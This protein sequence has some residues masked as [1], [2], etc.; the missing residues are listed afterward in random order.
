MPEARA[1][2]SYIA[3]SIATMVAASASSFGQDGSEES[4]WR[5]M[6][7]DGRRTQLS[8][9]IP[10]NE[11]GELHY[12]LTCS[13][14]PASFKVTLEL[15]TSL[16]ALPAHDEVP[17]ELAVGGNAPRPAVWKHHTT[18][19]STAL[20]GS[21]IG[22]LRAAEGE[23]TVW[24]M[25]RGEERLRFS[26]SPTGAIAPALSEFLDTC[27]RHVQVEGQEYELDGIEVELEVDL[28]ASELFTLRELA[29]DVG[30]L[31]IE[32][33]F[34]GFEGHPFARL[35]A[36]VTGSLQGPEARSRMALRAY[37]LDWTRGRPILF[38]SESL[39][40]TLTTGR[41]RSPRE[42]TR[43]GWR[44]SPDHVA[45]RWVIREGDLRFEV[46]TESGIPLD[47]VA[48]IVSAIR[49]ER[50]AD[51]RHPPGTLPSSRILGWVSRDS[52]ASLKRCGEAMQHRDGALG[53]C[54]MMGI[55]SSPY[56]GS[57]LTLRVIDDQIFLS[58][59]T[60]WIS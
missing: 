41:W 53:D 13:G 58:D 9:H 19:F 1:A 44:S 10:W 50:L 3:I 6:S 57:R 7:S 29:R 30:V 11:P 34:I 40:E 23:L 20:T 52:P 49:Q 47:L 33:I 43:G 37:H 35:V 22:Q 38:D 8:P 25:P 18:S 32:H 36:K 2:R 60:W 28:P 31:D 17:G 14:R 56:S 39:D 51:L 42:I 21:E 5:L 54:F 59:F 16:P 45:H 26:F 24:F 12:D 4:T 48:N 15:S 55:P 27:D 46:D